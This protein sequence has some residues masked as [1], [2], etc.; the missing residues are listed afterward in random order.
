MNTSKVA[1]IR[2]PTY[3]EQE[4]LAA[5]RSGVGLLG[6]TDSFA[7]SDEQILLKPNVLAGDPPDRCVCTHP[8]VLKAVEVAMDM[9]LPK[10]VRIRIESG[11]ESED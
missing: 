5:V 4:V 11:K 2:C 7:A 9:A 10:D 6:G 3:D 8:A 1:V